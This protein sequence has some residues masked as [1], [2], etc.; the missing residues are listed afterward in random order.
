MAGAAF[1]LAAS[2]AAAPPAVSP[3][4]LLPPAVRPALLLPPAVR[5][6]LLLPPAAPLLW[7]VVAAD[8]AAPVLAAAAGRHLRSSGGG[9]GGPSAGAAA[10]GR[11]AGRLCHPGC[12]RCAAR[13]QRNIA[14]GGEAAGE[15]L[16]LGLLLPPLLPAHGGRQRH[17][18]ER[19]HCWR[20]HLRHHA[21]A[22]SPGK[23]VGGPAQLL[24]CGSRCCRC[25]RWLLLRTAV[26]LRCVRGVL[27]QPR[28]W[29]RWRGHPLNSCV[30][31]SLCCVLPVLL[32]A[33]RCL[34][35]RAGRPWRQARPNFAAACTGQR[36]ANTQCGR[37]AERGS[38]SAVPA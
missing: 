13:A 8:G 4:L 33:L 24:G 6:P 9:V 36:G 15:D 12:R 16:Q 1:G 29:P 35:R 19:H 23:Q 25:R 10:G 18:E 5:P 7:R 2:G 38:W 30:S 21:P 14:S 27:P 37:P 11:R 22:L 34:W 28:G 31:C 26:C 17:G 3:A 32:L 20:V